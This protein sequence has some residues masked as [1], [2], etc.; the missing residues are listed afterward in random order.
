MRSSQVKLFGRLM[1]FAVIALLATQGCRSTTIDATDSLDVASALDLS[2]DDSQS[3]DELLVFFGS[4]Y[5]GDREDKVLN[6]VGSPDKWRCD[7]ARLRRFE[8]PPDCYGSLWHV[9]PI[10]VYLLF[11]DETRLLEDIIL[12]DTARLA[13]SRRILSSVTDDNRDLIHNGMS[14]TQVRVLFGEPQPGSGRSWRY[15]IRTGPH[16]HEGVLVYSL[17]Y[18]LV[19]S[20]TDGISVVYRQSDRRVF[21]VGDVFYW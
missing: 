3:L 10:D 2:R 7:L 9:G 19:G 14:E 16:S 6:K 15:G 20:R 4:I 17:H 11:D 21:A 8:P 5:I 13:G 12:V 18:P 1:S